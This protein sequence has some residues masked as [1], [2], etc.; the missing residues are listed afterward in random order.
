[1]VHPP[2]QATGQLD[3]AKYTRTGRKKP[4][5]PNFM[6]VNSYLLPRGL[7]PPIEG[8]IVLGP[9]GAQEIVDQWRPFNRGK[10]SADHLHDLYSMMLRMPVTIL[11]GG[12][13]EDYNIS[14]P[15]GTIKEDFQQM[16]EYGI[17]V[18][19]RNFDQLTELV[20]LEA[21]FLVLV[22]FSNHCH[23]TNMCLRMRLLLSETWPSSTENSRPG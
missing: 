1:M 23:I 21:F 8:V 6:L 2:E 5:L 17:Q 7:A 15:C 11:I 12:Q 16:I 20:S 4:L 13:G 22:L 10:S 18:R 3:R 14:V 19:N 9:E